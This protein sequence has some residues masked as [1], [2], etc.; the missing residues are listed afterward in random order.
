MLSFMSSDK[1]KLEYEVR[2]TL[3]DCIGHLEGLI[4]GLKSGQVVLKNQ[5]DAISLAPG[6]V[7]AFSVKA[8]QKGNK[9]SLELEFEWKRAEAPA[10]GG[11]EFLKISAPVSEGDGSTPPPGRR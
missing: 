9:E 3:E 7:V 1:N 4:Q 11:S 6:A 10:L 8:R 2:T 5:T